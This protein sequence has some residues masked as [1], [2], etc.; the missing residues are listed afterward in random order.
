MRDALARDPPALRRYDQRVRSPCNRNCCLDDAD[1]CIGC[2]RSLDEILG[3]VAAGE[4][5]QQAIIERAELRKKA[6]E[7]R[8]ERD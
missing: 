4:V 8:L 3:W 1:I 6:R 2:L 7:R 5:G